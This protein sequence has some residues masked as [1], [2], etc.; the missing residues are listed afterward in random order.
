M[1]FCRFEGREDSY[2][3]AYCRSNTPYAFDDC[4]KKACDVSD[5]QRP[6]LAIEY[7]PD[8]W[9]NANGNCFLMGATMLP[10]V[11]PCPSGF[12]A[13][14]CAGGLCFN[15]RCRPFNGP[16]WGGSIWSPSNPDDG[17]PNFESAGGR[18]LYSGSAPQMT[19]SCG[20]TVAERRATCTT[21][22]QIL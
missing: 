4:A 7:A 15:A 12:L 11:Q 19:V 3:G 2:Y 20:S 16:D 13:C 6:I 9:N 17:S 18:N 8:G 21:C 22:T 5:P 1:G 10:P 14:N